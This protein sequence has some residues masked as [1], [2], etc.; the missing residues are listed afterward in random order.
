MPPGCWISGSEGLVAIAA[1]STINLGLR[2]PTE[3]DAL[4]AGFAR[5]LHTITGS[6]QFLIRT[7][8]LDLSGHLQ[9]LREQARALPHPALVAA[10]DAHRAHLAALTRPPGERA[11]TTPGD[12]GQDSGHGLL[13]RQTLLILRE[14]HRPGAEQRLHR[15][16]DDAVGFL[17]PLDVAVVALSAEQITTL[18]ADWWTRRTLRP[19][20]SGHRTRPQRRRKRSRAVLRDP[21]PRGGDVARIVSAATTTFRSCPTRPDPPRRTRSE[22]VTTDRVERDD[23]IH[24]GLTTASMT[25]STTI[26][27]TH[28]RAPQIHGRA[29]GRRMPI[30]GRSCPRSPD[31]TCDPRSVTTVGRRRSTSACSMTRSQIWTPIGSRSRTGIWSRTS[32]PTSSPSRATSPSRLISATTA[33]DG[34]VDEPAPVAGPTPTQP[35][36]PTGPTGSQGGSLA[37][38]LQPPVGAPADLLVGAR[39]VRAGADFATTLV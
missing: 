9:T 15:R 2:T 35:T 11:T 25:V 28:G 39:Y 1:L 19:S 29:S 20:R 24:D 31:M 10:A 30:P 22:V 4:V 33:P 18:L 13:G 16:L 38:V 21:P 36:G 8:P 17:A 23:G 27:T 5:Y 34:G 7:V 26:S 14:H 6:V 3:Q 37:R 12:D 32:S